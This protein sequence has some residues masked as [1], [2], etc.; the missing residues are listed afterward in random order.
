MEYN[1]SILVM[2]TPTGVEAARQCEK[3]NYFINKNIAHVL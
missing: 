1:I 2:I 3:H